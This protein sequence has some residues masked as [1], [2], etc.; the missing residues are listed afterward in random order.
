MIKF[1]WD[2]TPMAERDIFRSV[3]E[4]RRQREIMKMLAIEYIHYKSQLCNFKLKINLS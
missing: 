3:I 4:I 1:F 2:V